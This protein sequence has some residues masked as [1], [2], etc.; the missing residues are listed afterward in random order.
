M[1]IKDSFRENV[2]RFLDSL[3]S[4]D[5]KKFSPTHPNYDAF[6][7]IVEIAMKNDNLPIIFNK[8]DGIVAFPISEKEIESKLFSMKTHERWQLE[9]LPDFEKI[10]EK[11]TSILS[12]DAENFGFT[13]G[14]KN[15]YVARF[16]NDFS[17]RIS[18][19]AYDRP[20]P[21]RATSDYIK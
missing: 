2:Y 17:S 1:E 6:C 16:D 21:P 9:K 20:M 3:K 19:T 10:I 15:A 7:E 13:L 14:A 18:K 11:I 5:V 12:Q 4:G 8:T